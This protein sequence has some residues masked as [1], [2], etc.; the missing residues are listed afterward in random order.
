MF[1]TT[2]DG[3]AVVFDDVADAVDS[4][5]AAQRALADGPIRVRIGMHV[6][7]AVERDG[8]FFGPTVNRTA[9][10]MAAGHGGQVLLS[11]AAAA[12]RGA[13]LSEGLDLI[14]LGVH[15]LK[16]LSRSEHIWQ[17]ASPSTR[18]PFPPLRADSAVATNL[19]TIEAL[20]G[21][22]VEVARVMDLVRAHR[23]VTI[24]GP[25][26]VGKSSLAIAVAHE[27]AGDSS[28][29]TWLVELAPVA[30]ASSLVGALAGVLPLPSLAATASELV[31][32]IRAR[33]APR[34]ARQL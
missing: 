34:G 22:D 13:A 27:L 12:L 33:G 8:D 29:G 11:E 5:V 23:L 3:F 21:R 1:N 6:G 26:G 28:D 14:D 18:G 20:L 4:V 30:D 16:G 31:N 32:Q 2:G 24:T 17:L 19:P 25:G 9:R 7:H 15:S 10:V